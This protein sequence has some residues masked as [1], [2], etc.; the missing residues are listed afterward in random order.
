MGRA[1]RRQRGPR[2]ARFETYEQRLVLSAQPV[3]ALGFEPTIAPPLQHFAELAPPLEHLTEVV[4]ALSDVHATTGVTAVRNA[5]GFDGTGQTVVV[6]DSGIAWNHVALGGGYGT[7][8]RVV[9][10]W[11][12]AEND[13]NPFDDGPSGF[14]GTHVAGI[15]GSSN[16][17]YRGVATGVDL[18]G[19]RV[20]DD[21]GAGYFHWVEQALQWVHQHR[22]D[23]RFPIT[24]VNLSLGTEW[25]SDTVPNWSM[26]E[27][28]FAQLK[29]DGIFISVAAGNSFAQYNSPGLSYPAA[30]PSVVPV[31]SVTNAGSFS[32]FSQ[33]HTRGL[34][35]PGQN[36]TSTVPDHVFGAD[37]NPNDFGTASGTSMAAPYLAGVSM[38]VREAMQFVGYTGITQDTIYNHLRTTADTFFD[39]AT[40]ANYLRVNA[41]RA[42][43]VLMPSDDYGSTVNTA[44]SLGSLQGQSTVAGLIG[45]LDDVDFLTFTAGATGQLDVSVAATGKLAA[46]LQQ[47]GG[48]TTDSGQLSLQV[49]AGQTYTIGVQTTA[50]IGHYNLSFN[51]QAAATDLGNLTQQTAHNV[52]LAGSE[53]WFRLQATRDGWLTAE[54][55]FNTQTDT[56]NVELYSATGTRLAGGTANGT[57]QRGDWTVQ[58][59]QTYLVR[60][61]GTSQDVDLRLTNL[62]QVAGSEVRVQGT[63][64]VDTIVV[65]AGAS[66]NLS[67]N[68]VGY[69]FSRA[70]VG[71]CVVDGLGGQDQLR[72]HGTSAAETATLGNRSVDFQGGGFRVTGSNLESVH[73]FG[74]GGADVATLNGSAGVDLFYG[75]S[76][77][78]WLTSGSDTYLVQG[79]SQVNAAG[80]AGQDIA[81]LFDSAGA[82]QFVAGP[83]SASMSGTGYRN[84]VSGFERVHG[85]AS[86]GQD[87]ATLQGST[88]NDVFL[89]SSSSSSLQ[90]TGFFVRAVAFRQV[91]A[92]SGGGHDVATLQGTSG[93]DLF[94]G[95]ADRSWMTN[96]SGTMFV[97]GFRQVDAVGGAG[98]DFAYLFDTAGNDQFVGNATQASLSGSNFYNGVAGFERVHAFSSGG[99]DTA[100][101]TGSAGNDQFVGNVGQ[102]WLEGSGFFLRAVGF[103]QVNANAGGGFDTAVLNGNSNVDLFYGY[104]DRSWLT[105]AGGTNLARGFDQ[106][107]ARGGGGA[108]IAYLFDTAGN[109]VFVGTST[110]ASLTGQ[111]FA[112]LVESFRRVHAFGTLGNDEARLYDSPHND[113]FMGYA[114][115]SWLEGPSYYL[116]AVAFKHVTAYATAG[117]QDV[118]S[119]FGTGDNQQFSVLDASSCALSS[120][121]C[122]VMTSG[123]SQTTA[124]AAPNGAILGQ[125][126]SLQPA[127]VSQP[128][129]QTASTTTSTSSSSGSVASQSGTPAKAI[130]VM[131]AAQHAAVMSAVL[132]DWSDLGEHV[133][134]VKLKVGEQRAIELLFASLGR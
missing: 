91:N 88:G 23:F 65:T 20:F 69:Q 131:S 107:T 108:D 16:S 89:G 9:G 98:A 116:R 70:A 127:S 101:L 104:A 115:S 132:D 105:N 124:Y 84:A 10:G 106:V 113:Q 46:R 37:G 29:S 134:R 31:M 50:G 118:A 17:T 8:Y 94:Y 33:R 30:S 25:N 53:Q 15:I 56:V 100:E 55:L 123:F 117:G 93:N 49:V 64:A 41:Q 74:G 61:S 3:G 130:P 78:S 57:G 76:Q 27:D 2:T 43:D 99:Q 126:S 59:N 44:S 62:V 28:E 63:D 82:D 122:Y 87:V 72:I 5:Y 77:Q 111:G 66:W 75:Y 71:T 80:G 114:T 6:I 128:S 58:A 51:L 24:T 81:Y 52:Q 95:Y 36:I 67:V 85:F 45:R 11:D 120:T 92:H 42:I 12:F 68:G 40:N 97:Q 86:T 60:L 7:G 35:A 38:L 13:A 39:A 112:N 54:A 110:Q 109:E 32:S 1:S 34:A 125:H 96:A 26:L 133:P 103:R 14:H 48:A 18:V 19:L 119:L 102:S 79:F 22:S 83:T 129:S 121:S 73:V 90:G 21:N 4:P 47:V